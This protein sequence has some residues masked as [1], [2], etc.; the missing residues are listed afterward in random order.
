MGDLVSARLFYERAAV[1]GDS[2]A[3]LRLAA[4]F[5]PNFLSR[6]GLRSARGDAAEARLWYSRALDLDAA[7]AKHRP[8]SLATKQGR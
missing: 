7:E 1:A 5:D 6:A 4:T 8:E 3:A 2:G